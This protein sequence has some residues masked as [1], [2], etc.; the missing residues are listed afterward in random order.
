MVGHRQN[1]L[2]GRREKVRKGLLD[3][4]KDGLNTLKYEIKH[5]EEFLDKHEFISVT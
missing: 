4:Q 2:I 3:S 5:Q 1:S